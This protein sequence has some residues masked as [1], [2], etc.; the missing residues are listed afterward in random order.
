MKKFSVILVLLLGVST[1][2]MSFSLPG[3]EIET[4]LS[5]IKTC[6]LEEVKT[7][8]QNGELSKSNIT[9]QAHNIAK[10]CATKSDT[11]ANP[12]TVQLAKTAIQSVLK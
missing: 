2:A 4:D 3:V 11:T 7:A 6:I 10:S 9:E 5:K 1:P 12:A 8:F